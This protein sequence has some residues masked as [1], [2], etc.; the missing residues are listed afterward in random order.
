[1]EDATD[2][3]SHVRVFEEPT[4]EELDAA[5]NVEASGGGGYKITAVSI[6]SHEGSLVALVS[7]DVPDRN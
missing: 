3:Q 6:A 7:F 4:A 2:R 5:I 1:M